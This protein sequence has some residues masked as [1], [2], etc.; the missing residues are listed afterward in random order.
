MN[1]RDYTDLAY[2]IS[3]RFN[4]I[5]TMYI[6]K[7][8]EQLKEIGSL[9]PSSLKKIEQLIKMNQNIEDIRLLLRKTSKLTKEEL[10]TIF[11]QAG[12]E[13]YKDAAIFYKANQVVQVPFKQ[14][15]WM[16]QHIDAIVNLTANTFVNLA[17][18]TVIDKTYKDVVDIAC[19]AVTGGVDNYSNVIRKAALDAAQNGLRVKYA[20]GRTRRLDSA[21]RMN[22]LEGIR[23]VNNGVRQQSGKEFGA[24]G[25]EIS[26]HALCAP[27]HVDYQGKQ[28]TN[29]QFSNLQNN[30]LRR[31]ISTC[32]CKH[33]TFPIIMG[34]STPA[35]S[36]EELQ[37]YKAN[38]EKQVTINGKTMTK[39][40]ATQV[41][42]NIETKIRYAKDEYTIAQS[43]GDK[44]LIQSRKA[45]IN[46]LKKVYTSISNQAGLTPKWDRT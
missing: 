29:K 33:I 9:N 7:I 8:G 31:P 22:V 39:Y 32:N 21:I 42:R 28:F 12:L 2:K 26:V 13:V 34:V 3:E 18:T 38:S 35:Y 23:Q 37:Q 46:Q 43:M 1:D 45:K 11:N 25:V 4:K 30:I 36:S 19:E 20:S 40:D 10:N 5:N 44:E 41:Q 17:R 16:Q 14:N 6:T 15:K 24:D 27:D